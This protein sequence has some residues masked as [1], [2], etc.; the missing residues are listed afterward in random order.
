MTSR[1]DIAIAHDLLVL[2]SIVLNKVGIDAAVGGLLE[3]AAQRL[4]QVAVASEL[5]NVL[6]APPAP[7][8]SSEAGKI[9]RLFPDDPKVIAFPGVRP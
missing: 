9:V 6:P 8:V 7:E 5:A 2:R 4:I 1:P 3:E